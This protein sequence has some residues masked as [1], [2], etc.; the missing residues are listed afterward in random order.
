[1][2]FISLSQKFIKKAELFAIPPWGCPSTFLE[3]PPKTRSP[4]IFQ[5]VKIPQETATKRPTGPTLRR[6]V[7]SFGRRRQECR[8]LG[9]SWLPP[10]E[11]GGSHSS[12]EVAH[13]WMALCFLSTRF[14]EVADVLDRPK[15]LRANSPSGRVCVP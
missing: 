4:G 9:Q 10:R 6:S 8:T 11:D 3:L 12:N 13:R 14:F 5:G 1:M 2:L 15:Y 7:F